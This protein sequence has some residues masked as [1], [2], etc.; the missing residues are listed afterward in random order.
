MEGATTTGACTRAG[1]RD[2]GG[3]LCRGRARTD[4]GVR[5]LSERVAIQRCTDARVWRASAHP[6]EACLVSLSG[7]LGSWAGM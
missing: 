3:L 6:W 5:V 7:S 4:T 2:D 1:S